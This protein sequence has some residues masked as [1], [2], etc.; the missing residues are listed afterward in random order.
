MNQTFITAAYVV[1]WLVIIGYLA[2]LGRKSA[3]SRAEY[4][5]MAGEGGGSR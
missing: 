5:R 2:R 4:D 1:T 3:R